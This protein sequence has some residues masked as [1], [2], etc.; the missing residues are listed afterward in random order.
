M[1]V[2][3][4]H[5]WAETPTRRGWREWENGNRWR[6]GS[7]KFLH[8]Y[9]FCNLWTKTCF[10]STSCCYLYRRWLLG[11]FGG[12]K[13]HRREV[14]GWNGEES[15][16]G[17]RQDAWNPWL[18]AFWSIY[19]VIQLKNAT[20]TYT[21]QD[22]FMNCSLNLEFMHFLLYLPTIKAIHIGT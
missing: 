10:M 6:I 12:R 15:T 14:C 8:S 20:L 5:E 16:S 17:Y 1:C 21:L 22:Y 19:K 3:L 13:E 9:L 7:C 18:C 4:S 11:G 2:F